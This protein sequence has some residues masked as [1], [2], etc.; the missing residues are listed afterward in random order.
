MCF[1]ETLHGSPD[2]LFQEAFLMAEIASDYVPQPLDCGFV[3]LTKQERGYFISEYIEGAID[4]ETWLEKYG[5][6]DVQICRNC[7]AGIIHSV[8]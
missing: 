6:L 4:G 3:D 5:K 2:T 1:W 7:I 8:K